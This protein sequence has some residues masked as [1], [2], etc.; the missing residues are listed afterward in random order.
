MICQKCNKGRLMVKDS[1][2]RPDNVTFRKRT[3]DKCGHKVNTMEFAII[4]D[5]TFRDEWDKY[6][7][8]TKMKEKNK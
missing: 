5:Q 3:C 7:R 8:L 6:H 1:V 2:T 4:D